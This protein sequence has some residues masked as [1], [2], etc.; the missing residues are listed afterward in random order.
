MVQYWAGV[1][2]IAR[3]GLGRAGPPA[4]LLRAAI[5]HALEFETWRSL[6][7]A[8]GPHD[9]EAAALMVGRARAL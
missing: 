8:R 5:G 2:E 9:A 6:V 7:A 4:T 3:H 1:R